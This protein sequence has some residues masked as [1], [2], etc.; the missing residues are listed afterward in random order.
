MASS[1]DSGGAVEWPSVSPY[2]LSV[3]G[4]SLKVTSTG[5]YGSESA[6]AYGG[7]G[8]SVYEGLP[9]YQA[10]V[11]PTAK[12]RTTPDVSYDANPST[13]FAVY[14]STNYQGYVG[15]YEVGGTSAG[16]PQWAGTVALADQAH[17]SSLNTAQVQNTLYGLAG[18]PRTSTS[19]AGTT[20]RKPAS[21]RRTSAAWLRPWTLRAAVPS[22]MGRLPAGAAGAAAGDAPL[23]RR[24]PPSLSNPTRPPR[25]AIV[26]SA[27]R[28]PS[29][30][31]RSWRLARRLPRASLR[32][33]SADG[34]L[35]SGGGGGLGEATPADAVLPADTSATQPAASAGL[36]NLPWLGGVFNEAVR[37]LQMSFT[38]PTGVGP[39]SPVHPEAPLP[40]APMH[41]APAPTPPGEQS[42]TI[43][44]EKFGL[45]LIPGAVGL[46][47]VGMEIEDRRRRERLLEKR[48]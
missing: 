26:S 42:G 47:G 32:A 33:L 19:S 30:H 39:A 7:G 24:P 9:S 3:G 40:Q 37:R 28:R 5:A 45:Y 14:D 1:G 22:A 31:T 16:S 6:W 17:G 4:T 20:P 18:P 36:G 13:G 38:A 25:G 41:E 29:P 8:T 44:L 2:V 21:A 34:V 23:K 12:A 11:E 27:T 10:K 35:L 15:W 46:C 48:R 43:L